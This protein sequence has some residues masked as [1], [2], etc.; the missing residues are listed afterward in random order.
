[1]GDKSEFF[2]YMIWVVDNVIEKIKY[3]IGLILNF[4]FNYGSCYEI[5]GVI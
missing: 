2:V 5:M 1:M 4:V 3:N